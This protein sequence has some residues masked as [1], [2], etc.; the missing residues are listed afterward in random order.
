M[1]WYNYKL[2]FPTEWLLTQCDMLRT[3]GHENL[4]GMTENEEIAATEETQ[5]NTQKH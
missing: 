3:L 2:V 1:G 4:S 5:I